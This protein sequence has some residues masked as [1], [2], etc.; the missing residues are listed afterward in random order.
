[1]DR[2]REKIGN[3]QRMGEFATQCATDLEAGSLDTITKEMKA[4]GFGNTKVFGSH[5][6]WSPGPHCS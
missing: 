1:M 5:V 2:C 4:A 6:S 3:A